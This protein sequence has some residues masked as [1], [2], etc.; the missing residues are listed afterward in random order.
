MKLLP[1]GIMLIEGLL[2]SIPASKHSREDFLH[3]PK[4]TVDSHQTF[5]P[6]CL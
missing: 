1:A 3:F 5:G 2:F 4:N 6:T